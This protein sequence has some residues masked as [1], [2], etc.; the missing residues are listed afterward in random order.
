[1]QIYGI[2]LLVSFS[3]WSYVAIC[4][5]PLGYDLKIFVKVATAK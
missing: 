1:M 5:I 2:F 4:L 3:A